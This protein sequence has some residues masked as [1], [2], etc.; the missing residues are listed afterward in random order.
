MFF[1]WI[2]SDYRSEFNMIAPLFEVGLPN[3]LAGSP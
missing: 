2:D 1:S 3:M